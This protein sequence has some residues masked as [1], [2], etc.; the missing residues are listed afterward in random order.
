MRRV[1][2]AAALAVLG[3]A[4]VLPAQGIVVADVAGHSITRDQFR[5][6]LQALRTEEPYASSVETVTPDG[7]RR[8]LNRLVTQRLLAAAV[9]PLPDRPPAA[10]NDVAPGAFV[11]EQR[12]VASM[13]E[14]Y[15][16]HILAAVG[17]AD[18]RQ[19]YDAHLDL[20]RSGR[21]VRASHILTASRAEAETVLADLRSGKAFADVARAR[22]VDG[23]TADGG[24]DLGWILP[25]VMVKPFEDAV[26]ALKA[27]EVSDIVQTGRGFHVVKA[28][29]VDP[30]ALLPF[31]AVRDLARSGLAAERIAAERA[32][33]AERFGARVF[34]EALMEAVP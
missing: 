21:R 20:F 18:V 2:A 22:S 9:Q 29:A 23:A 14:R 19:Y 15:E 25:G 7:Q 30:G 13:A 33:L 31:A 28:D 34:P 8:L 17:E 26:F 1:I 5:A 3:S 11:A 10:G 6:W 16:R 32:R 27:G 24:G 4:A 12:S